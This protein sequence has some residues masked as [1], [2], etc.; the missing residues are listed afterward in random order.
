MA[1]SWYADTWAK[2]SLLLV[3]LIYITSIYNVW[4]HP[5]HQIIVTRQKRA[6]HSKLSHVNC[7]LFLFRLVYKWF[8]SIYKISYALGVC[9]YTV[10][11]CTF[12]NLN[13]LFMIR[14]DK[15]MDFGLVLLFYGLYYGVLGRDFAE[16]CSEQMATRIG[17]YTKTGLPGRSLDDNICAVCGQKMYIPDED[18]EVSERVYE[19]TCK[20]RFHE[21]CIRGWCIVGKR[22][23]CPYCKEKVD[24]KR[25]FKNPWERPHVLFGQ[26]LDW[27]RYLVAWQPVIFLVVQGINYVL[28]LE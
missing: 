22:Q 14:T 1:A 4:Y 26:L 6:N 15:S 9:G 17:Y 20:H 23:T 11:M 16:I 8:Y 28:G 3:S 7:F 13:L 2:V 5:N 24:L 21:F 10:V 25:M 12:L 27:I 18:E 19:L